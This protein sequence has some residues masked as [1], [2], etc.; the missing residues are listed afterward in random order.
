MVSGLRESKA[1]M[2]SAPTNFDYALT[3]LT[4]AL[5]K[6][7]RTN[8]LQT[9][10]SLGRKAS[11]ISQNQEKVLMQRVLQL[12]RKN[13]VEPQLVN[14]LRYELYRIDT[15]RTMVVPSKTF[16]DVYRSL[17]IKMPLED[18]NLL[19]EYMKVGGEQQRTEFF[20][21]PTAMDTM[22]ATFHAGSTRHGTMSQ[23]CSPELGFT[24]PA[25]T[26]LYRREKVE[27][28]NVSSRMILN[29]RNLCKLVDSMSKLHWSRLQEQYK[30]VLAN[31]AKTVD[32]EA[33]NLERRS[34]SVQV[35]TSLEY[36]LEQLQ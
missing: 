27:L 29:I 9:G 15:D 20:E 17:N 2:T 18:F 13:H 4:N 5:T 14:M 10:G 21:E 1:N 33:R 25:R 19:I 3:N 28:K 24:Q 26:P 30:H 23:A 8:N 22:N 11:R 32:K 12:F 7:V 16:K 34:L 36:F 35:R 31:D 6:T